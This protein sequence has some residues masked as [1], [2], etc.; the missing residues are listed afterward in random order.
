VTISP[1]EQEARERAADT[2]QILHNPA[3]PALK[4]TQNLNEISERLVRHSAH[5]GLFVH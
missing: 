4:S 3:P 5:F 2:T 1:G